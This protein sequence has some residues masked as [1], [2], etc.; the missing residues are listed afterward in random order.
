M[1]EPSLRLT[2]LLKEAQ[3]PQTAVIVLDFVLGYGSHIDPVGVTLPAILEAKRTAQLDGRHLEII[4][5]VC[6]TEQDVQGRIK[7]EQKL[8]AAG[9]TLAPSNAQAARLAGMIARQREDKK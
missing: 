9:V 2:R 1:I 7:Q 4:G 6:G 5:Y 8:A 3:D